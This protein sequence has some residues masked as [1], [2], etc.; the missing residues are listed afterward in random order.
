MTLK[1]RRDVLDQHGLAGRLR[2]HLQAASRQATVSGNRGRQHDPS[3]HAG[4]NDL[5]QLGGPMPAQQTVDLLERKIRARITMQAVAGA[6]DGGLLV[7]IAAGQVQG[8]GAFGR[9]NRLIQQNRQ[10]T[11]AAGELSHGVER[12]GQIVSDEA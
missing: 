4:L 1:L 3:E 5:G 11:D 12:S 9:C 7:A 8:I 6:G 2:Q 10:R